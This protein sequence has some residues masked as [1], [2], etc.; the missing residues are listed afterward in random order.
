MRFGIGTVEDLTWKQ[1][2]DAFS[3][4]ECGRCQDACPAYFTGK[5]LSPKL[6]IMG[7]RDH[8]FAEGPKALAGD[9]DGP[10]VAGTAQLE[11]MAWDCVT[12]GACVRGV[13]GQHRAHRPHRRPAAPPGDGRVALPERG[14]ADAARRRA[15]VATRG[16]SRR[17]SATDWT[18]G[19]DVRVLEPG[20][21]RARVPLLGRLRGVVRR[22]GARGRAV[23][24]EAADR[25]R[26]RLRDPRPARGVHRRPRAADGQRVRLPG[27]RRAERRDAQR[28]GR[29]EDRREL[30]ALL[31]HDRAR[32]PRLRR[33][34]RG[35][36][37]HRAARRAACATAACR[38]RP[39]RRRSPTTTPATSPATTTCAPR[40]ASWPP[41]SGSRSRW[42]AARRRPSAAAPAARTCGWRSARKPI[43]EERVRQAAETGA[44]TLAVACPFCTVMLDDGVKSS[45]RDMRVVDL[46]T[47]LAEA[48]DD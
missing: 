37:P 42:S 15:P 48:I 30:P 46:A 18:E 8:L 29:D 3:C 11:E 17:P 20:D 36:P 43:N 41:P 34:L 22:A 44:G 14:R 33:P 9:Y 40:R 6:V 16:A 24:G 28:G 23:D 26:R 1:M 25:R 19:L 32:V 12:C 27:L 5:A 2:M 7:V 47:L 13:P 39:A 10:P 4:T 31:Q 38:R 45:G 21:P 35:R